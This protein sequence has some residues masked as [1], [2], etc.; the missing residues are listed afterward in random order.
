MACGPRACPCVRRKNSDIMLSDNNNNS[1]SA[2]RPHPIFI[3]MHAFQSSFF[4][5][6]LSP[7]WYFFGVSIS[8]GIVTFRCPLCKCIVWLRFVIILVWINRFKQTQHFTLNSPPNFLTIDIIHKGIYKEEKQ[9]EW[10]QK[11][12]RKTCYEHEH[13]IQFKLRGLSRSSTQ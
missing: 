12:D 8:A 3:Q 1:W 2:A 11:V 6:I 5:F 10:K 13:D 9:I 7:S 4:C